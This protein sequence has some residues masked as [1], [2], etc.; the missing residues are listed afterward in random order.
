MDIRLDD[1]YEA[2][3]WA[4]GELDNVLEYEADYADR[5]GE[6]ADVATLRTM[7]EE[8]TIKLATLEKQRSHTT[9]TYR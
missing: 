9:E 2:L 4:S 7:V 6:L 1:V 8:I 3:F 5:Q